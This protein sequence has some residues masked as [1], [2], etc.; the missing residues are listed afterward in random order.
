MHTNNHFNSKNADIF[1]DT[2]N[3]VSSDP[4]LK[5]AVKNSVKN[6]VIYKTAPVCTELRRFD[7]KAKISVSTQRT[8]E[9][10]KKYTNANEKTCVLNFASAY[11]PGG[12][13]KKGASAQEESLC[14][15]ST[16][17]FVLSSD[18]IFK[19]HYALN[20]ELI[21]SG[22]MS[23]AYSDTCIYTPGIVVFKE[24]DLTCNALQKEQRFSVDVISCAAPDLRI[25]QG[26]T[27][28]SPKN[29]ELFE[30]HEQ[31]AR[32]ILNTALSNNV[33]NLILGAFGCGAFQNPPETVAA[34]YRKVIKD[35]LYS[36]R[37]I[38]FS[39]Y[40]SPK[41]MLNY[42]IFNNALSEI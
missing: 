36:F 12:G 25:K 26:R 8:F 16:L 13:V 3:M 37:N 30:V 9:A 23:G 10:A 4:T 5:E 2:Q 28:F 15:I 21:N 40:C 14:R 38:E 11:N 32:T 20:R 39:V 42:Q 31:R 17:Y 19:K 24:D 29:E 41:S 34:V 33:D 27:N 35:Y 18:E 1:S 7:I 22:K 6:H